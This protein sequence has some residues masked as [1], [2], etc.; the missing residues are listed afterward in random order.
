MPVLLEW[1]G[2]YQLA[3]PKE[4]TSNISSSTLTCILVGNTFSR[5]LPCEWEG[6]RTKKV[7]FNCV[8]KFLVI[9]YVDPTTVTQEICRKQNEE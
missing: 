6:T 4:W 7:V 1:L 3:W 2:A 9:N 8:K 5:R